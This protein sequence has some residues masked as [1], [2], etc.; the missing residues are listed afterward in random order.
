MS[1]RKSPAPTRMPAEDVPLGST[2]QVSRACFGPGQDVTLYTDLLP[3]NGEYDYT[4]D[5]GEDCHYCSYDPPR[6]GEAWNCNWGS[7]SAG[8]GCGGA[9]PGHYKPYAKHRFSGDATTCCSTGSTSYGQVVSNNPGLGY[10]TGYD[11]SNF[12]TCDPKYQYAGSQ[13]C[14][15]PL[16]KF[17]TGDNLFSDKRCLEWCSANQANCLEQRSFYCN[18]P[19]NVSKPGCMN[20]CLSNNGKCDVGMRAY[21]AAVPG[22]SACACINSPIATTKYNPMCVDLSCITG[23]YGT[24]SMNQAAAGGCNIVD[25][26]TQ[27]NLKAQNINVGN[28]KV[29]QNCQAIQAVNQAAQ[30]VAQAPPALNPQL[31]Q[32]PAP[33][34]FKCTI[35]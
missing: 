3:N 33:T 34:K 7:F 15:L 22:A 2:R 30:A 28:I 23:G 31:N 12:H 25:C 21:C 24:A 8:E 17:C 9:Y 32:T 10:D 5:N 26:S 11:S 16:T 19:M 35:I 6:V 14:S 18:D 4:G 29:E 20:W 27:I 1:C 13:E